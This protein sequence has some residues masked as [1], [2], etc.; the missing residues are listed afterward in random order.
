MITQPIRKL[1]TQ[2][3]F[4]VLQNRVYETQSEAINC[5]TGDILLVEDLITGLIY[6]HSFD[7]RK[8]VY[9]KNYQNEQAL[10][11]SFQR[12]LQQAAQIIERTMGF[13]NLVELGCGKGY[14]MDMLHSRGAQIVG[15]D[16]TYEGDNPRVKRTFFNRETEIDGHGIVLRHVLEHIQDPVDFLFNIKDANDG[17]GLIY[18]EVPCFDWILK[19]KAWTDIFYEHVNYFRICDFYRIFENI[20]ESGTFFGGQYIYIVAELGSIRTPTIDESTR[21]HFPDDFMNQF[22]AI[23]A[24][25]SQPATI[26][27]GSSKG[28]I[29]S[30]LFQRAGKPIE[31]VIDINPAK[32]GRFLPATGLRVCAPD[33]ALQLIEDKSTIFIMNSNYK[34]EIMSLSHN[35]YSYCTI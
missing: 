32:Q 16:P 28:V 9:D 30:L 2:R 20:I 7:P 34:S 17:R 24:N 27:G 13:D 19:N 6:N 1:Y 11:P 12:H 10:S 15:F 31:T 29:F 26:W 14:F 25:T 8:I 23:S 22:E 4:P 5:L 3:D 35:R 18:I 21:V 33:E